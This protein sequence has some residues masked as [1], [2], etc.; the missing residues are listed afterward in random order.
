MDKGEKLVAKNILIATGSS[1]KKFGFIP[2]DAYSDNNIVIS[3]PGTSQKL[4]DLATRLMYR[5]Q[6]RNFG[7]YQVM[8][9]NH[10]VNASGTGQAGVRWY[11]MRKYGSNDWELYQQGTFA[12]A[13]GAG[14]WMGSVAMN[15]QGEIAVGYSVSS[16]TIFPSIRIAGQSAGAPMG[17]GVLDIEEID[18]LAGTKSQTGVERWGDYSAMSVD[19]S[20][21]LTFWFTTQYSNGGWSWRTRISAVNF[22]QAPAPDFTADYTLIPVGESVNFFDESLNIP[23]GWEWTFEGGEPTSSTDQDPTGITYN[24]EGSFSVEL[25]SS[26]DIGSNTITKAA[27]ITTSTT[28]LPEVD[29]SISAVE[30]CTSDT[31]VLTD[32]SDY[33]PRQ[34]NWEFVPSTV[35]FVNGTDASSQNPEVVF[36]MPGTY[37]I[38]LTATNLNGSSDLEK[39]DVYTAGGLV[40]YFIETFEDGFTQNNW[41]VQRAFSEF[42]WEIQEIGGTAPGNQAAGI[43]L[44]NKPEAQRDRLVSPAFNLSGL[45]NAS[46]EFQY[47]YA[48]RNDRLYDSLIV[49]ISADCGN[50]WTRIY[51]NGPDGSGNFATHQL[52][53]SFW[54]E[55]ASDWCIEGW[56]ATCVNLDLSSWA[57]SADVKIAFESFS[58][59]GNPLFIDNVAISQF[60][61]VSHINTSTFEVFPNP[62]NGALNVVFGDEAQYN[63][64]RVIN[65]F[66]QV[67]YH[68]ALM[69]NS[70][71]FII[72]DLHLTSGMYFVTAR[73]AQGTNTVKVMSY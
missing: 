42:T 37:S 4:D 36:E 63:E 53:S 58:D 12:P 7:G 16:S 65:Q 32:H 20:D 8:V 17:L 25:T 18:I 55:T 43:L 1:P 38:K 33:L 3:Q 30:G 11:E 56:G 46:L 47:A 41:E 45:S 10:T 29:F 19:P 39:T 2:V 6:Y 34:W 66:G 31:I 9:T 59:L 67:L 73:G 68:N 61:T 44:R 15:D 35:I 26:N 14:R 23:T 50:T 62:T 52:A 48:Q 13:D 72:P 70:T 57:G 28:I 51:A 40:P 27:Y 22:A 71:S 54:P 5:L 64:I 60:L 21:G 24:T 69:E 49:L